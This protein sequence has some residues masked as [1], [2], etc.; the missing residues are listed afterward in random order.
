MRRVD[1]AIA[2]AGRKNGR[3]EQN[4]AFASLHELIAPGREFCWR[5]IFSPIG[6]QVRDRDTLRNQVL[7]HVSY[8]E[9]EIGW[10]I[11]LIEM[12]EIFEH[13]QRLMFGG[14]AEARSGAGPAPAVTIGAFAVKRS[15]RVGLTQHA[16]E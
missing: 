9:N 10:R 14:V 8:S 13:G 2:F 4:A 16:I 12:D 6:G 7:R 3:Y 1:Q 11:I 5:R 15:V